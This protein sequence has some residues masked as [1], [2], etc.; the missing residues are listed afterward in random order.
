MQWETKSHLALRMGE[1][2][3]LTGDPVDRPF[4]L[5]IS[6]ETDATVGLPSDMVPNVLWGREPIFQNS[7]RNHFRYQISKK[8][9]FLCVSK[10]VFPSGRRVFGPGVSSHRRH[11][12]G[13]G[14]HRTRH[15]LGTH[16]CKALQGTV[17]V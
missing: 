7:P 5:T 1:G 9:C 11:W 14:D 13:I 8:C 15:Q 3:T 16:N 6:G 2:G 4:T 17:V 12:H 10:C